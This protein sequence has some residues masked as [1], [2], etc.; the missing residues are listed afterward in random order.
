M[1]V[2]LSACVTWPSEY[3]RAFIGMCHMAVRICSCL[4]RP[5][6]H[7]RQNMFVPLSACVIWPSEYVRTFISLCHVAVRICVFI[8]LYHMAV[9]INIC[10]YQPVSNGCQNKRVFIGLCR[11]NMYVPF[12]GLCH[13]AVRICVFI[14]LCH[15]VVGP[16]E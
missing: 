14:G 1:F 13:I 7:S 12:T 3:V 11:Q 6:S 8:G 9:R 15:I 2:P 4:Y 5:V 16:S 10:L